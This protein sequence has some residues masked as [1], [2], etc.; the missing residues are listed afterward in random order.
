M[1]TRF[2]ILA[3]MLA[4]LVIGLC[5]F[6]AQAQGIWTRFANVLVQG[7]LYVK[8]AS[9]T[10]GATT[11]TGGATMGSALDMGNNV[12]NNIGN[13]GTDFNSGGGLT[14]AAGFT[15]TT[16]GVKVTAG[17]LT[18]TAGATALNGGITADSPAFSV[19]DGTGNTVISGTCLVTTSLTSVG[20]TALNGGLA[21]D[22]N[23]FA[24]ADVS[25][26]TQI[27][28]T[29]GVT[30]P[31][32]FASTA[33]AAGITSTVGVTITAGPLYLATD[34][35][36]GAVKGGTGSCVAGTAIA[37]S[38]S[39]TP[40]AIIASIITATMNAAFSQTVVITGVTST[41]FGCQPSVGLFAT[42][43][44]LWIGVK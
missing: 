29:L 30:S 24:V 5:A 25:G 22:T 14:A 37:H 38:F 44:I 39:S 8:G 16:A 36:S 6:P 32:T 27:S 18:V 42:L 41:G 33:S 43:P 1:K 35:F 26:N 23:A 34:S 17:G 15:A 9:T 31:V 21:M 20:A 7:D 19:A 11:M 4:L 40:T 13:A 28:G 12:I 3:L 10:V 2:K